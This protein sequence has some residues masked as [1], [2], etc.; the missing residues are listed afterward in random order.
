MKNLNQI[1][2]IYT[3]A[4]QQQQFIANKLAK[5]LWYKIQKELTNKQVEEVRQ[6]AENVQQQKPQLDRMLIDET[7]VGLNKQ[8][9]QQLEKDLTKGRFDYSYR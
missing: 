5:N 8:Q 2:G 3:Q 7:L 4:G 9:M 1:H 6:I